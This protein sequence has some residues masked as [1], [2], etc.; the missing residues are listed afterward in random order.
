MRSVQQRPTLYQE[1]CRHKKRTKPK[2][3][4]NS[5]KVES[6]SRR[7]R[8]SILEHPLGLLALPLDDCHKTSRRRSAKRH[9]CDD[10]HQGTS[11]ICLFAF[12]TGKVHQKRDIE[13]EDRP[14]QTR[15]GRKR[16]SAGQEEIP[17]QLARA[18]PEKNVTFMTYKADRRID[19]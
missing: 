10:D 1:H 19:R 9:C 12:K 16:G 15:H 5:S 6:D 11:F 13:M 2:Y 3:R 18:P 17:Q 14:A 7:R 8:A 4:H